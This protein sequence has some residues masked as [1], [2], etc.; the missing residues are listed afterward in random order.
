MNIWTRLSARYGL[1]CGT[2]KNIGLMLAYSGTDDRERVL[3]A[4]AD[5]FNVTRDTVAKIE[6]DL[7][8]WAAKARLT[9]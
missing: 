2:V 7:L 1:P 5:R 9:T 3:Q 4:L 8:A 6:A